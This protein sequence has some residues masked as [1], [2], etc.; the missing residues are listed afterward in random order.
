MLTSAFNTYADDFTL[1][2]NT[3]DRSGVPFAHQSFDS[4][5]NQQFNPLFDLGS[6]HG[7]LLPNTAESYGAFP[8]PMVIME[9]YGVY[10]AEKL[11]KLSIYDQISHLEY[12]L[13]N[14]KKSH[15]SLPGSLHQRYQ[16]DDL[17]VT[18][19]LFFVSERTALIKTTLTNNTN[20]SLNLRLKWHGE[21]LNKW[22]KDQTVHD[23]FPTWQ[24]TIREE[25]NELNIY[26]SQ[27]RSQWNLMTSGTAS[28]QIK[29]SVLSK[30]VL[31]SESLS[32]KSESLLSIKAN[33][34][35]HIYTAQ[36][37]FLTEEERKNHQSE[38][39]NILAEPESFIL[40]SEQRWLG[41][42]NSLLDSTKDDANHIQQN[43]LA[44]KSFETLL[45]NWRSP[46]GQIKHHG[47]SPSTTARWFN[48]FW[49][50]DSWK[51]A[52]ALAA[53]HPEL[54]KNIIRSMFDYQIQADDPLRGQDSG[55]VID[56]VFYNKDKTRQGDGGNWNE[57]NSK[58]PLASWAIWEI[59]QHSQ[60]KAFIKEFFP[61]LEQ[62]HQWWYRNRDHNQNGLIEYGATK[63]H[64]H[65]N[66]K[67]EMRFKVKFPAAA[68]DFT[69]SEQLSGQN[70]AHCQLLNDEWFEC[71]GVENHEKIM[72]QNQ[73]S[74]IDIGAQHGAG[75]E[76]GMDNAARFGF[77]SE[78]QLTK[79]A[80]QYYQGDVSKARQDWQVEILPNYSNNN[81][82]KRRE[83]LGFSINQESVELNAYLAQ[84]KRLLAKMAKVL[85]KPLLAADYQK[86][87]K[88]L[89]DKIDAC[90]F[91][92]IT[93]FYYDRKI[94][95]N[96]DKAHFCSGELL[97]K[98]GRGPEGWS[99]L[100]TKI[101]PSDKAQSVK[102][103]MLNNQEFNSF[104]PFG[105]AALSNPAYDKDIYWRGRVW[106]DQYY[107]AVMS[108]K[109]YG[110]DKEA[111]IAIKQLINNAKGLNENEAIR[112][113]Y[114]P[115]TG[116]VQGATNFSWSAAH[117]LMLLKE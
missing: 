48:G 107:F 82:S 67:G 2:K 70:N 114:N 33:K 6:W 11:D 43:R 25:N 56:A 9:E 52:Y 12:S 59:Y 94:K 98:R 7:F 29:R 39:D 108:L 37:Y 77:I 85:D 88:M 69:V 55:M 64:L 71:F 45:G 62:Y 22:H 58:P 30:N 96:I 17:T 61:K 13:N 87:Y 32:Y 95:P 38:I 47:V 97:V 49:A 66:E 21:L 78:Q 5:Q 111:N 93:G 8:G 100:W 24:R 26:F 16:F 54:A 4:Y 41:Y 104:I 10:I 73:Y 1:R 106:L 79:Y 40:K 65:N 34:N 117:L 103:V 75:W 80:V 72:R 60:D 51:H 42:V 91:D 84:E 81:E 89:V 14:A 113:N 31:Q 76:S 28:Y 74:A 15:Y 115:E 92:D 116:A 101:A 44:I 112:E 90:F 19:S 53:S 36:S 102:N 23:V 68:V 86:Q 20:A 109:N 57:R 35:K 110:F 18:L 83:L 105:T 50:W 27:L 3:L 46:S 63:H 99:P